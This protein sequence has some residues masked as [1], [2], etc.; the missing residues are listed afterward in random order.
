MLRLVLVYDSQSSVV[1]TD[2]NCTYV[3]CNYK[4]YI[5]HINLFFMQV[6][7]V[8]VDSYMKSYKPATGHMLDEPLHKHHLYSC[9]KSLL[10]ERFP[11]LIQQCKVAVVL[12]DCTVNWLD[13]KY[14]YYAPLLITVTSLNNL[15]VSVCH[16]DTVKSW[17]LFCDFLRWT[18]S[19]IFSEANIGTAR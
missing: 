15:S 12:Y 19:Q 2:A 11:D 9:A 5:I 1:C 14:V 6:W 10:V 13:M 16:L 17:C 18:K 8:D 7:L 3:K 4:H